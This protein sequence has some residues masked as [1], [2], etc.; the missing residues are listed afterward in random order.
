MR[1]FRLILLSAL[2][3]I[4]LQLLL[5]PRLPMVTVPLPFPRAEVIAFPGSISEF[6][7]VRSGD[8]E[9]VGVWAE[10]K[11]GVCEHASRVPGG[12]PD[13]CILV[14]HHGI[15]INSQIQLP[16]SW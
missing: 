10:C 2:A 12:H 6:H 14:G 11:Y 15:T 8:W 1:L 4:G 16:R 13:D 5:V 9:D 3:G 7:T